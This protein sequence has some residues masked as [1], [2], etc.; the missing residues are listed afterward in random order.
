MFPFLFSSLSV[1]F[2]TFPFLSF[3]RFHFPFFLFFS[4]LFCFAEEDFEQV[5]AFFHRGVTIA[6]KVAA[7]TG[8]IKAYRAALADGG[9]AYPEIAQLK[10]DVVA[11]CRDFPVVGFDDKT[12]RYAAK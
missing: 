2:L 4:G 8:K 5:G 3:T 11:F 1:R 7:D 10:A 12:M 9:S 6:Q